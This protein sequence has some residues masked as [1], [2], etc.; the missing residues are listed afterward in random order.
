MFFYKQ[1]FVHTFTRTRLVGTTVNATEKIPENYYIFWH[2]LKTDVKS[3][4]KLIWLFILTFEITSKMA[5]EKG[6][7]IFRTTFIVFFSKKNIYVVVVF[8]RLST[9]SI[10]L[11][12]HTSTQLNSMHQ[13]KKT[14]CSKYQNTCS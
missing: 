5:K 10:T 9:F 12:K 11:G 13:K 6:Q 8:A 4:S 3:S 1:H 7:Q 14:H 2:I